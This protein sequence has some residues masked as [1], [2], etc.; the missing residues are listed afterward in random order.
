MCN[1]ASLLE[2]ALQ[3]YSCL[4]LLGLCGSMVT[5]PS[6]RET[7]VR[8]WIPGTH[9]R[10]KCYDL[11]VEIRAFGR[12]TFEP[13][14][15]FLMKCINLTEKRKC[16][17]SWKTRIWLTKTIVK[18][19]FG[20][21]MISSPGPC[22][23]FRLCGLSFYYHKTIILTKT[24]L[25]KKSQISGVGNCREIGWSGIRRLP[26]AFTC[27]QNHKTNSN[28]HPPTPFPSKNQP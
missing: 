19:D 8:C 14:H 20:E 1:L 16:G 2:D 24:V 9:F 22:G 4:V 10:Q 3:H 13:E 5:R 11:L 15:D 26:E 7:K 27:I 23:H 18:W 12:G 25:S 21:N 6:H 28:L 17:F